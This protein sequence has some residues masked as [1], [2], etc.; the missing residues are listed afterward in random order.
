[1]PLGVAEFP[2]QGRERLFLLM[3]GAGIDAN[4]VYSVDSGLKQQVGILAYA[5]SGLQLMMHPL[6]AITVLLGEDEVDG[7]TDRNL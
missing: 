5:W 2:E 7:R 1:V 4:A 6:S 3:C